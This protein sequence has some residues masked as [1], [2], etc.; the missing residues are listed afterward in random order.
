MGSITTHQFR[1][2]FQLCHSRTHP[3]IHQSRNTG[4]KEE[5]GEFQCINQAQETELF[6]IVVVNCS[7]SAISATTTRYPLRSHTH[8]QLAPVI[9]LR[10]FSS[11]ASAITPLIAFK[12]RKAN[13]FCCRLEFFKVLKCTTQHAN[14]TAFLANWVMLYFGWGRT[15]ILHAFLR[16]DSR[17]FTSRG[18]IT[19]ICL[20]I[21]R[22]Q[23]Y[24]HCAVTS[25]I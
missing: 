2:S 19:H 1:Q 22:V 7:E 24:S 9:L 4:P 6:T 21:L 3:R 11:P 23:Q 14:M 15:S 5:K 17:V 12:W 25:F 20:A 16:F 10:H 18:C 13:G 8:K